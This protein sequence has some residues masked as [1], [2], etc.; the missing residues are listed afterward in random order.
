MTAVADITTET[1]TC[2]T[3]TSEVTPN[4]SRDTVTVVLPLPTEVTPATAEVLDTVATEPSPVCQ[5]KPE[6][7]ALPRASAA[8]AVKLTVSPRLASVAIA[9]EIERVV[10]T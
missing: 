4:P 5:V 7:M 8:V 2:C 10:A 1:T 3:T 9:G 6:V